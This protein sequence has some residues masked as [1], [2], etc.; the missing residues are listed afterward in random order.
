MAQRL[1]SVAARPH[2]A[3]LAV[4]RRGLVDEEEPA[5]A[6]RALAHHRMA[7]DVDQHFGRRVQHR[8]QHPI[9]GD[10]VAGKAPVRPVARGH[11][12]RCRQGSSQGFVDDRQVG[13]RQGLVHRPVEKDPKQRGAQPRG[14]GERRRRR[15]RLLSGSGTK[16]F[17]VERRQHAGLLTPGQEL[18]VASDPLLPVLLSRSGGVDER[19][20][21]RAGELEL[22]A[23]GRGLLAGHVGMIA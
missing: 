16:A 9:E 4:A 6:R 8:P 2:L 20:R 23:A 7:L 18:V 5:A 17:G 14:V 19:H 3:P 21:Q 15:L 1:G 12:P 13:L 11:D 22:G 10:V